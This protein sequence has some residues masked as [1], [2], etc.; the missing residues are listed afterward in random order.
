MTEQ[1]L[2]QSISTLMRD[3]G[4]W[5]IFAWLYVREK[6]AHNETIRHRIE[7]LRE[8]AGYKSNWITPPLPPQQPPPTA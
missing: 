5:A 6:Q 3:F 4:M 7:D 8:Q 2:L 1:E